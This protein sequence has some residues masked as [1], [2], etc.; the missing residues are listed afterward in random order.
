MRLSSLLL[1]FVLVAGI[2]LA[3]EVERSTLL[4][5]E[6]ARDWQGVGRVNL[7]GIDAHS[8]CTGTL[9]APDVVLTAAHCVVNR[10]KGSVASLGDIH[11]V[12]GW[13]K[14]EKTGH[15]TAA[16]VALHPFYSAN[17]SQ[18]ENIAR[19]VA[20]IRLRDPL[21]PGSANPFRTVAAPDP[22]TPVVVLS[23]RRDRP[24]ALT[25]QD[26]CS[27][28]E[29]VG[30]VLVLECPVTSGASGAPVFARIEGEWRQIAVLVAVGGGPGQPLAYAV[31]AHAA[32]RNL[33]PDLAESR[34]GE[35]P[36]P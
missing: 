24:H 2:G 1:A 10:R 22:G 7:G 23:Y 34:T 26:D 30:A 16:A 20:L 12:A 14:G 11:F 35:P 29:R 32:A 33:L 31:E 18:S 15:S 5:A 9:L 8:L 13:H 27:Y 28:R 25:Y 17:S 4:D 36:P 3:A 21:P 6:E 19:D